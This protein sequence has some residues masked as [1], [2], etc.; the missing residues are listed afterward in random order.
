MRKKNFILVILTSLV[1]VILGQSK[2]SAEVVVLNCYFNEAPNRIYNFHIDTKKQHLI[3]FDTVKYSRPQLALTYESKFLL[4][5]EV[6]LSDSQIREAEKKYND[7]STYMM[8]MIFF[9]INRYSG[10]LQMHAQTMNVKNFKKYLTKM[11]SLKGTKNIYSDI[12][13][14]GRKND[15]PGYRVNEDFRPGNCSK[16]KQ[17]F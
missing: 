16:S 14:F 1:F 10:R 17:K 9:D 2:S 12:L 8:R 6:I 13:K 4:A 11:T 7:N 3:Q 15:G 5:I